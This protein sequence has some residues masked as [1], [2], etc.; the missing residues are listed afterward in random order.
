M[1][2]NKK[3]S[4]RLIICIVTSILLGSC[5]KFE[6]RDFFADKPQS[7]I[8]QEER[9][10]Y[11]NL[12]T[13]VDYTNQPYFRLGV[14][15]S[16]EDLTNNNVLY[17]AMQYHFDEIS[18]TSEVSHMDAIQE[19]GTIRVN[20]IQEAMQSHTETE[21]TTHIGHLVWHEKQAANYLNSLIEDIIIP[22]ESGTEMLLNFEDDD[23]NISYSVMG[24][25][26][27]KVINDPEG[28]SGKVLHIIGPQTFPQF[29][30][31]LPDELTLGDCKSVTIDFKGA[32][33]CGLYGQGMRMG[34][35][36]SLGSVPLSN[37]DSPAGFGAPDNQWF[38]NGITL[39]IEDLNL[40]SAQKQLK[41]FV[42]TIGSA[43]G[44]AD[45]LLDNISL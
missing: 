44:E 1:N 10:A 30:V 19:D 23:I 39:P 9:D 2:N 33:C 3:W 4:M 14:E 40:S 18:L 32:G 45:Y 21:I 6:K 42:L 29:E 15:L 43:T 5:A 26:S 38:R 34:I 31:S 7:L 11:N 12:K 35:S 20:N 16:L 36:T 8:D 25:G 41:N 28:E 22:G 24:S 37:Y 27:T 17:R 13:Y